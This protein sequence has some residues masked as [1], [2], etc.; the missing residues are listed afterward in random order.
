MRLKSN[1]MSKASIALQP[2]ATMATKAE[3][4]QYS[5]GTGG[6]LEDCGVPRSDGGLAVEAKYLSMSLEC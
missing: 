4:I 6:G 2:A 5:W 3:I 1:V